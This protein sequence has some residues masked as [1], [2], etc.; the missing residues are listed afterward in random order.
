MYEDGTAAR[1]GLLW[2]RAQVLVC[3]VVVVVEI[4][5]VFDIIDHAIAAGGRN[6]VDC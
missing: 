5:G 1:S 3:A 2:V 4:C 6:N